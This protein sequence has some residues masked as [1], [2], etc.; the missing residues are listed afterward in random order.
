MM[1]RQMQTNEYFWMT[2]EKD[3]I[4]FVRKYN[5]CHVYSDKINAPHMPI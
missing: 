1:A 5:K 4:Q 3:C 2:I